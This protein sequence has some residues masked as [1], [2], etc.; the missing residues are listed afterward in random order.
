MSFCLVM[1]LSSFIVLILV[2]F[3]YRSILRVATVLYGLDTWHFTGLSQQ[4]LVN[5]F[6]TL[7]HVVTVIFQ[8]IPL[9]LFGS[10]N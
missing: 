8:A 10:Y 5:P 4:W 6:C 1:V 3:S 9:A 2:F 7:H